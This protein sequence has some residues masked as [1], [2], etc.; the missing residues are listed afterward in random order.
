MTTH[1][2]VRIGDNQN[3]LK[4]GLRRPSLLEDFTLREMITHFD[5]ERIPERVAHAHVSGARAHFEAYDA[6]T[7][8]TRSAPFVEKARITPVFARFSTV[9]G[10]FPPFA[11]RLKQMFFCGW[12]SLPLTL[13]VGVLA[14]V[15][16]FLFLRVPGKQTLSKMNAFGLVVTVALGST[17]ATVL[18]AKD[19]VVVEGAFAF[20]RLIGL[21]FTVT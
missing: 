11:G 15:A 6:L 16:L 3:T 8:Y 4:A 9:A 14:Y 2:G 17:L 19:V 18:P 21:R 5:H 1:Q 10:R 20:A 7:N 12:D 13:V